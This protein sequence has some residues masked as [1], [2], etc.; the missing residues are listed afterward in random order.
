[1]GRCPN[2]PDGA[3]WRGAGG[4]AGARCAALAGL[5]VGA[6]LGFAGCASLPEPGPRSVSWS[7]PA[8]PDSSLAQQAAAASPDPQ[9]S[10]FYLMATG[11][12]ALHTR[13]ELLRR[14][15]H[16]LDVQAYHIADD[17]T[18]R[19]LLRLLRDAAER[20]VR[21]RL[22]L[23]D[24]YTSGHDELLLGLAANANV[25][26]RLFNPFPAGRGSLVQRI[27]ASL[28]D[29][30]RVHRRMHNKLLLADGAMAIVGGRN[31]GDDYFMQR[32]GDN[33]LDL[34]ALVVGAVLPTLGALF[35]A[36]WNSPHVLPIEAIATTPLSSAEL[37]Q[38]FDVLTGPDHT[39]APSPPA[40]ADRYGKELPFAAI[41]AGRLPWVWARAEAFADNPD[42]IFGTE[43]PQDAAPPL[44]QHGIRHRLVERIRA[45]RAE[46]QVASPYVI[47]TRRSLDT[48][49]LLQARG[50]RMTVLTN[51]LAATDEPLVHSAY[52]RYRD[53]MLRQG[54]E[55]YELAPLRLPLEPG[56]GAPGDALARLH[57]KTVIIDREIFFI[58][59]FN[60]DHRS[61]THN[62]ELGLIVFSPTLAEQALAVL[63]AL[64]REGAFRLQL[65]A[66]GR[67]AEWHG[68]RSDGSVVV[69]GEPEVGWSRRLLLELVGPFVPEDLL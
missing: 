44:D 36:Y 21:V 59:S 49:K 65:A 47:P 11:R 3:R 53:D 56:A 61:A 19:T 48:I 29:F 23:D 54:V 22:L 58:G 41:D 9:L 60:F 30:G 17:D 24:L 26:L 55:L 33:F 35:D 7:L 1:V 57:A 4:W 2:S 20:G 68:T 10:G 28:F 8:N 15:Q 42:K 67:G 43:T 37:R 50:V 38:R 25:E 40:D 5:L 32:P 6:A 52:R 66:D 16:T 18:G 39:A 62:T 69:L 31:I 12:M 13:L 51:S 63:D 45:A 34:D 46:V 27:A 14:A 64:K